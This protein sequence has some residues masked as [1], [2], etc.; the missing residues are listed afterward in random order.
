MNR[1]SEFD[2]NSFLTGGKLNPENRSCFIGQHTEDM[3]NSFHSDWFFFSVQSLARNGTLYDCFENEILPRRLMIN[4]S[5]KCVFL[6]DNSKINRF[7]AYRQC[8]I[9]EIDYVISD[10]EI[11][12]YLNK[13]CPNTEYIRVNS[14]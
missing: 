3:I 7:S 14:Q 1:C 8:D 12:K 10:I 5:E 4:N 13:D 9:S 11:K 2:I 6:C